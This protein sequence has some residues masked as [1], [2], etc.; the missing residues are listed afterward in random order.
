MLPNRMGGFWTKKDMSCYVFIERLH[1][2]G[3][4]KGQ[5]SGTR[6]FITATGKEVTDKVKFYINQE[7][8]PRD[9][10]K[11]MKTND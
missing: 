10:H 2:S 7:D 4:R 3:K 5:A 6:Y 1:D 11:G 9:Y 8:L